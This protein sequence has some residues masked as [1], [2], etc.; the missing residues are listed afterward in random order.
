MKERRVI[1]LIAILMILGISFGGMTILGNLKEEPEKEPKE[2]AKKYVLAKPVKYSKT[3]S[4]I[5]ASGRVE[6]QDFFD[7]STEVQ[8]KILRGNVPLKKGQSFRQGQVIVHI[9]NKEYVL[10]L[11]AHKSR[12]LNA[13]ANLLP[14]FKVDY[15]NSYPKWQEFF[16]KIDLEMNLP[17]LP[18]IE[19][20]QEKIYLA[21]KNLLSEY[22]TIKSE[23][24]LLRKYT[25]FAPFSGSFSEVYLHTGSIAN[26][27]SRI[28]T[29]I[30]TDKLELEV[31]V[32][33]YEAKWVNIGD[34]VKV[35][36]ES[37][38]TEWTGRV[39]RKSSFINPTTQSITVFVSLSSSAK[40]PIYK[41][42]YL[43]AKFPGLTLNQTMEIP[44]NAVFNTNEV[45][46]IKDSVLKKEEIMIHKINEK[47]LIFSGL[48]EGTELVVEPLI[49]ATE[50]M[51]VYI[52]RNR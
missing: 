49:N 23:E 41:G 18:E 15:P 3:N 50:N 42:M 43:N 47:T 27:G 19:S 13:V 2:I 36:N 12:F 45:F 24:E 16:A 6:S 33:E 46:T 51:K 5:I 7:L 30:R 34:P 1:I 11:K 26:P 44:R 35:T 8:G 38:D 9:Y 25:I 17:K 40:N 4:N 52:L 22:Y 20:E 21:S 39:V 48:D 10:N 31:P 37:G 32:D 29:I 28:A 14:D